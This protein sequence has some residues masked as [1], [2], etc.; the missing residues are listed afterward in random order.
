LKQLIPGL[1]QLLG[2]FIVGA[3]VSL[4]I[5]VFKGDARF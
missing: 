3:S 1:V 2:G 5:Q 4:L